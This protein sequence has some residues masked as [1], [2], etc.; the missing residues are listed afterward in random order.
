MQVFLAVTVSIGKQIPV[1]RKNVV[2]LYRGSSS[3]RLTLNMEALRSPETSVT[4]SS[5]YGLM[6]Q[7]NFELNVGAGV[8][9]KAG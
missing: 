5:R 7:N 2:T 8:V 4:V 3:Q 9:M 6:L 1:F